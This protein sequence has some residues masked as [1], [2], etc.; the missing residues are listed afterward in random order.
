MKR[1]FLSASLSVCV[2]SLLLAATGY[3][4]L[5]GAP[6]RI[7]IPFDFNI[8]GKTL[9]AGHYEIQRIND[10]VDSLE[11]SNVRKNHEHAMFET[12]QE[13]ARK[14][15]N[16]AELVFHRYGDKYFLSEI[17]TPGTVTGRELPVSQQERAVKREMAQ[18]SIGE[19]GPQLVAVT[20]Q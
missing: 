3:A 15:P 6:I 19:S 1:K 14:T 12:D 7:N 8:R 17:W 13:V 9:P 18:N 10:E 20:I 5:S 2:L 4:Q 16:H 11:I